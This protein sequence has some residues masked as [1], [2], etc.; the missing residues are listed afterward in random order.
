MYLYM[1]QI[2]GV[3]P[4]LNDLGHL[5]LHKRYLAAPPNPPPP[6]KNIYIY[7]FYEPSYPIPSSMPKLVSHSQ[8]RV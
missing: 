6:Q 3:Y 4:F 1:H 7:T 5:R 8:T 2:Y